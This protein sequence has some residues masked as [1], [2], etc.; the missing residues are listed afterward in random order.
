MSAASRRTKTALFVLVGT[1]DFKVMVTESGR[2]VLAEIAADE[3]RV[4]HD[5]FLNAEWNAAFQD[6]ND[7]RDLSVRS[8][9]D[10]RVNNGAPALAKRGAGTSSPL[11]PSVWDATSSELRLAVAKLDG[12][13]AHIHSEYAVVGAVV[14]STLRTEGAHRSKEPV[15]AGWLMAQWL[16]GQL[17]L[18]PPKRAPTPAS[19]VRAGHSQWV[20]VL[21]GGDDIHG[22]EA[23]SLLHPIFVSRMEAAVRAAARWRDA[24]HALVCIGGG[25]ANAKP[26]LLSQA[27]LHFE[28]AAPILENDLGGPATR[29]TAIAPDI[30][31]GVKRQCLT[32]LRNGDVLGAAAASSALFA[33]R[34]AQANE[35]GKDLDRA[36][37][38]LAAIAVYAD[39]LAHRP[40]N[41]AWVER[42]CGH[43]VA[44]VL[45]RLLNCPYP[46]VLTAFRLECALRAERITNALELTYSLDTQLVFDVL[47]KY[48]THTDGRAL[49][50]PDMEGL[51]DFCVADP[52]CTDLAKVLL[53]HTAPW[54]LDGG[55][56]KGPFKEALDSVQNPG[57]ADF[58]NR[59]ATYVDLA[60]GKRLASQPTSHK[61]RPAGT[62]RWR[63]FRNA[64]V[65]GKVSGHLI[66]MAKRLAIEFDIW[67]NPNARQN[68]GFHFLSHPLLA[69]AFKQLGHNPAD[70]FT[71]LHTHIEN[72]ILGH[73]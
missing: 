38:W 1:T 60:T 27:R 31:Y 36:D 41:D 3:V 2:N 12:L 21:D 8:A 55:W 53:Q 24:K 42:L 5:K 9:S 13:I 61:S 45:S 30:V 33:L 39:W 15:A 67:L 65:H 4:V 44:S 18:T 63:E 37:R 32:L 43:P 29:T 19:E 25:V 10:I 69:K 70:D 66:S 49:Q 20:I 72:L 52:S 71:R 47:S 56:V 22:V 48:L 68:H 58:A 7:T 34:Q 11:P 62:E 26:I 17:S 50:Y 54:R 46:S 23:H 14:F 40:A 28:N 16:A 35:D 57:I 64:L 6:T 51:R 73:D 59:T